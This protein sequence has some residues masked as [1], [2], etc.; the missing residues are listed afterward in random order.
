MKKQVFLFILALLP[1]IAN[2]DE[3]G[4]CGNNVIY[5]YVEATKTLTISGTGNM[6][7]YYENSPWKSF[8]EEILFLK[9]GNGVT[10]IGAGAFEGCWNLTSVIIPN[11]VT[12]IG[13]QAFRSCSSL[14]SVTISNNVIEIGKA[15][16]R[17]CIGLTSLIIPNSVKT[18]DSYAFYNCS[19]LT[20]I[21]I[22]NSVTTIHNSVFERCNNLT[23]VIISENITT[24]SSYAFSNCSNLTFIKIPNGVKAIGYKAFENC[25]N[26]AAITIGE[27][28]VRIFEDAF[29]NCY[30]LTDIFCYAE[31]VPKTINSLNNYVDPFVNANIKNATLHVPS[32]SVNL[33]KTTEPWKNFKNIV[34]LDGTMPETQKC[35]KPT[36]GYSNGKLIFKSETEGAEFVSEITDADIKKY[37]DSEVQLCV[38]YN[39]SVY[40]TKSGYENSDVATATLCWIDVEPK[41]EGITDETT[42]AKRIEA[43]PVLI[44]SENGRISVS[45]ADDGTAISVYGTNGVKVGAAVS[46]SGQAIVDTK[47]P[48]GSVAIVKIGE[49]SVKVVV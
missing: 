28:V 18:I 4:S 43:T 19:G 6:K 7:N 49:K 21:I 30:K 3:S 40:A 34:A 36:I 15:S 22:P 10:S 11:S 47:L 17:D 42:D 2:A 37:Y 33:Y 25:Q 26:L 32:A 27:K 46:H 24:I 29:T 41:K 44:Q 31:T 38:T 8:C 20:S 5:T 23:S 35:E 9:I 16:F 45:G 48:S 12:S 39:I 1:V 14:T 13:D